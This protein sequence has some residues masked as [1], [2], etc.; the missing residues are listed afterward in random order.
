MF[1]FPLIPKNKLCQRHRHGR[2]TCISKNYFL[3]TICSLINDDFLKNKQAN[4]KVN[5]RW[6][7][8]IV[9]PSVQRSD[10]HTFLSF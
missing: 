5:I 6:L 3:V 2:K 7:G 8:V 1:F 9:T 10:F 4:I